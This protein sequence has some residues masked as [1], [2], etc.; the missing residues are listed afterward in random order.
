MINTNKHLQF[1]PISPQAVSY[2]SLTFVVGYDLL[3]EV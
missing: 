2:H 1:A 3:G